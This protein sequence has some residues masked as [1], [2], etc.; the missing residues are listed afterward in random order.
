M[1]PEIL[2]EGEEFTWTDSAYAVTIHTIPVHKQ[3]VSLYP[4]NALF[5]RVLANIRV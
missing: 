1:H 3:P 4:A 5:D 2:F